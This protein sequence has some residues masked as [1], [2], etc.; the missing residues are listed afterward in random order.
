MAVLRTCNL[1]CGLTMCVWVPGLKDTKGSTQGT[2]WFDVSVQHADKVAS[3]FLLFSQADRVVKE[4]MAQPKVLETLLSIV[5]TV[6][7]DLH[8]VLAGA[9]IKIL[10]ALRSVPVLCSSMYCT[11]LA[12][13]LSLLCRNLSGDPNSLKNLQAAHAVK[14]LVPLL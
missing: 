11:E 6:T 8:H 9:S 2:G 10:K 12:S 4:D 14:L 3:I 1:L 13:H 7:E 5:A